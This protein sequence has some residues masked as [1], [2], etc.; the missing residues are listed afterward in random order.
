[1][2][3]WKR[4]IDTKL[5]RSG[6]LEQPEIPAKIL[7]ILAGINK[8][9]LDG[10]WWET[11]Q[12]AAF[13]GDKLAQVITAM[14]PYTEL[15]QQRDELLAALIQARNALQFEN[16]CP[17]G[18]IKDTLWMMDSPETLFDFMD[19]AIAKAKGGAQ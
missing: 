4:Q 18:G 9:E 13:G 19:A 14:E 1:M 6:S 8:T 16:D 2:S 11:N 3:D 5:A 15:K 7:E 17:E 12:G 10:G